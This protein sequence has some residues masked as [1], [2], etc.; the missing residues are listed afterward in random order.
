MCLVCP[1]KNQPKLCLNQ[2][3]WDGLCCRAK[4]AEYTVSEHS[5]HNLGYK[6]PRDILPKNSESLL[7][8]QNEGQVW[9]Q[10]ALKPLK[11]L[12]F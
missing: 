2:N 10:H 7:R 9:T 5:Q 3:A 1:E 11:R 6:K 12:F 8:E 4:S